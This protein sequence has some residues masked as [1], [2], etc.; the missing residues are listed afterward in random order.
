MSCKFHNIKPCNACMLYFH[1]T[2]TTP[3]ED[4]PSGCS[5]T[6]NRNRLKQQ[7]SCDRTTK[8]SIRHYMKELI[9]SPIKIYYFK[10]AIKLYY[11]EYISEFEKLSVLL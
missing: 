2:T 9:G 4:Y 5:I 3:Q 11:P 1:M 6:L 8:E 10:T 7:D